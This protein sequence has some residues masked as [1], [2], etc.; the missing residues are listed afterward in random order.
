MGV[1]AAT[2]LVIATNAGLIGISRLSWSLAEHRQLPMAFARV[3]RR[4]RTPWFTIAFFS[5]LERVTIHGDRRMQLAVVL[6]D[7]FEVL[8]DQFPGSDPPLLHR[9]LH[10]RNACLD[11]GEWR[12]CGWR[13][14][15]FRLRACSERGGG[16]EQRGGYQQSSHA[17][18]VNTSVPAGNLRPLW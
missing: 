7:A 17:R 1:L 5:F 6:F 8:P 4:Y 13:G 12:A 11:D 2:I 18:D 10:F 3:H 9:L 16:E 15:F 14:G